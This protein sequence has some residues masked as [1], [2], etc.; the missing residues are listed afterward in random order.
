MHKG[1]HR[2]QLGFHVSFVSS[3]VGYGLIEFFVQK[4]NLPLQAFFHGLELFRHTGY[5]LRIFVGCALSRF[6]CTLRCGHHAL[7]RFNLAIGYVDSLLQ[8]RVGRKQSINLSGLG[9]YL[10][11]Q[12]FDGSVCRVDTGLECRTGFLDI[13][14]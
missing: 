11:I 2:G 10:R 5:L 1:V 8:S 6:G 3:D 4:G 14:L 7:G 12:G 9:C 13:G